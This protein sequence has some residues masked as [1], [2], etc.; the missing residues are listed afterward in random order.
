MNLTDGIL[1][2][3]YRN[4]YGWPEPMKPGTPY[5][6]T[7]DV[8]NASSDFK[9]GHRIR[10]EVRSSNFPHLSRNTNT[11]RQPELGAENVSG[12]PNG[13]AR[14]AARLPHCPANA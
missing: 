3:R 10:V 14:L 1:R 2:T 11:G 4:G 12:A 9:T 5:L 7:V 6:V 8:G 13:A